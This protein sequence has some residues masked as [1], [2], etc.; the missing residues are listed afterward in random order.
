[1]PGARSILLAGES[2]VAHVGCMGS[3]HRVA[4][5][6]RGRLD[7]APDNLAI[8]VSTGVG[9]A[10]CADAIRCNDRSSKP[11]AHAVLADQTPALY[12]PLGNRLAH[13]RAGSRARSS[14]G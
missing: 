12:R 14:P 1:M 8:V 5:A 13:S 4:L 9:G 3:S 2:R 7:Y 11:K 6:T 10:P